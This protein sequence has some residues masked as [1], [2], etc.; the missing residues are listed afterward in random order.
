MIITNKLKRG[1]KFVTFWTI[2]AFLSVNIFKPC[3]NLHVYKTITALMITVSIL[4]IFIIRTYASN[5]K[6]EDKLR[7]HIDDI[8]FHWIPLL[9]ALL[10]VKIPKVKINILMF[11]IPFLLV[12]LHSSIHDY[13]K[14]YYYTRWSKK[15]IIIIGVLLYLSVL[16]KI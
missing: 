5:I 10:I 12:F 16:F 7:L 15:K 11:V 4:G 6:T 1:P 8:L 3:V 2:L 14:L 13:S 9:Y